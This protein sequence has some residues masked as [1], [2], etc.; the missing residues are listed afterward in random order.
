MSTSVKP[1][2][3]GYQAVI[4]YLVVDNAAQVIDFIK[5]TFGADEI[6]RMMHPDGTIGHTELRIRDCIVMLGGASEMWKA[7][8]TMLYLYVENVDDVY[9]RAVAAGGKTMKEPADQFYGDRTAAVI[10]M[11]GNQWWIATHVEEVSSEEMDKRHKAARG[12]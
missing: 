5:Q 12:A 9:R 1:I 2:P 6:C 3:D 8:P 10:D 11:S 4:P 7:M